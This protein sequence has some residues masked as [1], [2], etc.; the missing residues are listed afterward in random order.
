MKIAEIQNGLSYAGRVRNR[1]YEERTCCPDKKNGITQNHSY[2]NLARENAILKLALRD[3]C[4]I[5]ATDE[6]CA[7]NFD[8]L[9]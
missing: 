5:I 9:G 6:C 7:Q 4:R 8:R 3:A 2:D 1:N